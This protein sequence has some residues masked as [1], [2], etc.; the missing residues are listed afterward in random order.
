VRINDYAGLDYRNDIYPAAGNT[1]IFIT[2][3]IIAMTVISITLIIVVIIITFLFS[4][5]V[6]LL[7]ASFMGEIPGRLHPV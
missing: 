4:M 6:K 5:P 1:V 7:P 3:I 2:L